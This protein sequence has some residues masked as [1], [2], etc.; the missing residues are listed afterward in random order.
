MKVTRRSRPSLPPEGS[1]S[2]LQGHDRLFTPC[3]LACGVRPASHVCVY[4]CVP[5]RGC[6]MEVIPVITGRGA[7]AGVAPAKHVSRVNY[8]RACRSVSPVLCVPL[9]KQ[10]R[11]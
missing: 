8:R 11:A 4:M 3:L 7:L 9:F 1:V 5:E 10:I 2:R 6:G